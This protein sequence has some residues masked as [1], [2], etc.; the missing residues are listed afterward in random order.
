VAMCVRR[1]AA[2]VA[3]NN[4]PSTNTK[5]LAC[6]A[7]VAINYAVGFVPFANTAKFAIAATGFNTNLVQHFALGTSL[8]SAGPTAFNSLAPLGSAYQGQSLYSVFRRVG[9]PQLYH[10]YLLSIQAI[11]CHLVQSVCI[12]GV[13]DLMKGHWFLEA[14]PGRARRGGS[15][16]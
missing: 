2:F 5:H 7:D 12:R 15:A 14:K 8:V 16:K 9:V 3:P 10:W 11:A 13:W 6:A 4:G 1:D